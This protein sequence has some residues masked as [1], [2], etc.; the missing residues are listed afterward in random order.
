MRSNR[1]GASS[2]LPSLPSR[3][4][5]L[6]LRKERKED[7]KGSQS[8]SC[9]VDNKTPSGRAGWSLRRQTKPPQDA[10]SGVAMAE[11]RGADRLTAASAVT[12]L[13]RW[14]R[15]RLPPCSLVPQP[16]KTGRETQLS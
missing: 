6:G 10:S 3:Q 7:T 14:P 16:C 11:E 1:K 5:F 15:A 2:F 9:N 8:S 4:M 13:E 12:Y